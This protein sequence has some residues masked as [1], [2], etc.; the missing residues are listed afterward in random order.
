MRTPV[1]ATAIAAVLLGLGA[2]AGCMIYDPLPPPPDTANLPRF[3]P[4]APYSP[5]ALRAET[6]RPATALAV[7]DPGHWV[8]NISEYAWVPGHLLQRPSPGAVW[9]PG[10]WRQETAGWVRVGGY[11]TS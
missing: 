4:P 2:L 5:P 11:W 3:A 6:A 7:W 9:H 1:R 8:W 10:Y